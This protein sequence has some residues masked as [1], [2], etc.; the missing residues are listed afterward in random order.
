[1]EFVDI[2]LWFVLKLSPSVVYDK[3]NIELNDYQHQKYD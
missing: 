2:N 3:A 1:M